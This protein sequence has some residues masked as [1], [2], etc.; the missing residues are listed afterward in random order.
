MSE[1]FS[2]SDLET[3]IQLINAGDV[4]ELKKSD[5]EQFQ[6]QGFDPFRIVES[7]LRVKKSRSLSDKDFAKDV[8][9]MVAVGMIKGSV[10]AHN[11]T[12]M[13]DEGKTDL[14]SLMDKYGVQTGGGKGK[15]S[16]LV[17]FPRVMA[18]FPDVAIKL[19]SVIGPKEFRGGPMQ[20]TNLPESL[21]VQVFPA[22]IPREIGREAKTFL[23]TAALCYSIDQTIQ[24]SQIK[25]P[26]LQDI[27]NTQSRFVNVGHQSPVPSENVRASVFKSLN[28]TNFYDQIL[29]VLTKYRQLV[30]PNFVIITR[31]QLV[32][33]IG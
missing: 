28:I 20:S 13:S 8:Y 5:F 21:Q 25:E 2:K 19:V 23:M 31:D 3:L 4:E 32:K 7:L 16:A 27:A 17:T 26:N 24:I 22:I 14:K 11:M 9:T 15:S 33:S 10:N 30:D 18:T 12:K 6:Y 1:S 29:V